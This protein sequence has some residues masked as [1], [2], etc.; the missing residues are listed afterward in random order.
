MY[1]FCINTMLEYFEKNISNLTLKPSSN[2]RQENRIESIKSLQYQLEEI[3]D[4][5]IQLNEDKSEDMNTRI[6]AQ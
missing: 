3:Y 2:T 5:F 6:L 1:F 4:S